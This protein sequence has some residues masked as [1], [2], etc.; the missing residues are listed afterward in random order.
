MPP[1]RLSADD[2]ELRRQKREKKRAS[3]SAV[4]DTMLSQA[5]EELD[6]KLLRLRSGTVIFYCGLSDQRGR[7]EAKPR[8][9]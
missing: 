7:L 3:A 6:C 9:R 2:R 4:V 1:A 5:S 8:N